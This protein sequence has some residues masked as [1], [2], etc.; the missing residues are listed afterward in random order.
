MSSWTCE[1]AEGCDM[2][3][4]ISVLVPHGDRERG[5]AH[6][7]VMTEVEEQPV[8]A[9]GRELARERDDRRRVV[10]VRVHVQVC[11]VAA[12]DRDEVA[13][14]PEILLFADTVATE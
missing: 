14:S 3:V 12:A 10:V 5:G 9:G 2:S 8:R 4:A 1:P 11:Q 6:G 7:A 13:G